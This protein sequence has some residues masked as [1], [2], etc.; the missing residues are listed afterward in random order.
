MATTKPTARPAEPGELCTRGRP[1]ITVYLGGHFGP[2]GWCGR[3]D[4]GDQAGPCPFC[5]G[6]RHAGR[7]P[8]YR[9]RFDLEAGAA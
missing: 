9:L 5:R 3:S 1:V 7:C 8:S 6:S 4:G 2:T